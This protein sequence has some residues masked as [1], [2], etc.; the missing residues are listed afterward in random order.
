MATYRTL[1]SAHY[2]PLTT[3]RS[4][5]TAHYLLATNLLIR[6]ERSVAVSCHFTEYENSI[7]RTFWLG[8]GWG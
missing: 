6:S 5:L 1:L 2:F 7:L 3:Y 4:L 8:E